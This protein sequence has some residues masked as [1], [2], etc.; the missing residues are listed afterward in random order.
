[1]SPPPQCPIHSLVIL[2]PLPVDA[3]FHFIPL[4]NVLWFGYCAEF[5]VSL[6]PIP[7]RTILLDLSRG[8][9]ETGPVNTRINHWHYWW[10]FK[11]CCCGWCAFSC[12]ALEGALYMCIGDAEPINWSELMWNNSETQ[13]KTHT[14]TCIYSDI[15]INTHPLAQTHPQHRYIYTHLHMC[16][17]ASMN[18]HMSIKTHA[19]TQ[20]SMIYRHR[21]CIQIHTDPPR[22]SYTHTDAQA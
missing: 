4:S 13:S 20:M 8:V 6:F 2:F 9:L 17:E 22:S 1:M 15:W 12:W 14:C 19:D 21:R 5:S 3:Y 7:D 18:S 11:L 16:T 10:Q